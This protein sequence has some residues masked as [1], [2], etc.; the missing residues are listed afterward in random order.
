MSR[1]V[2]N[3]E[4]LEKFLR[5][6]LLVEILNLLLEK[7]YQGTSGDASENS[8]E[9]FENNIFKIL[10]RHSY[11]FTEIFFFNFFLGYFFRKTLEREFLVELLSNSFVNL[12]IFCK[13]KCCSNFLRRSW[14]NFQIKNLDIQAPF[15]L[16][17]TV[18]YVDME[19][20]S[21]FH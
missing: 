17:C 3:M 9:S 13:N 18:D 1:E 8:R 2:S 21:N 4:L 12:S 15:H 19:T 7:K 6:T 11:I 20:L 16:Y 14:L 10:W 5:N